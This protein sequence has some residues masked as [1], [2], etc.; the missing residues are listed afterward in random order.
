MNET[1]SFNDRY[2]NRGYPYRFL[3]LHEWYSSEP[4]VIMWCSL[5]FTIL[6]KTRDASISSWVIHM[7]TI[8]SSSLSIL[9]FFLIIVFRH[10]RDIVTCVWPDD[11]GWHHTDRALRMSLHHRRSKSHSR[12]IRSLI[13]LPGEPE[14]CHYD[15]LVTDD[16]WAT[17]KPAVRLEVTETLSWSEELKHMLALHAITDDF[18][19][20]NHKV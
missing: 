7:L 15:H 6:Y 14:S 4:F 5:C 19:W 18:T 8:P 9:F 10:P 1:P 20:Y 16:V 17:L 2:R 3:W 11:D 12:A 13:K